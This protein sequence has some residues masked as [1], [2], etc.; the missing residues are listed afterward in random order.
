MRRRKRRVCDDTTKRLI[1]IESKERLSS[2]SICTLSDHPE[3][4][5]EY[6][7]SSISNTFSELMFR[8]THEIYT[9]D[10]AESLWN[11]IAAHR[12]GLKGKLGRDVGMLVAAL[13][14]LSNISGDILNPKIMDDSRIEAAADKA[15]RDSLTGLYLRGVF[16]FSLELLVQQ[17]I[18]SN[19]PLC[20]NL[21]DIDDFKYVNDKYGH[22]KGD[23]VLREIG[24]VLL[25]GIRESDFAARYGGEELAIIFPQTSLD[26]GIAMADRLREGIR[27]HF[28]ADGPQITVSMGVSC[29][30]P[31]TVTNMRQLIRS[32]DRALYKAKA[33]G[34]NRVIGCA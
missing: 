18:G 13:D 3:L 17:H 27:Q 15:T 20:V 30:C 23:E 24:G 11:D 33:A 5:K 29:I 32:A 16:E 22:Q 19:R 6:L 9:E 26:E 8:L 10:K 14:Y 1:D 31:P 2:Q 25:M 21:V 34:K 28:S 7:E 12:E 4:L